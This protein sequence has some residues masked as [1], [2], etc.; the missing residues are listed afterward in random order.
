MGVLSYVFEVF[1]QEIKPSPR[2]PQLAKKK[3][4]L[5]GTSVVSLKKKYLR[6]IGYPK[7]HNHSMNSILSMNEEHELAD[8]ILPY[9]N[10]IFETCEYAQARGHEEAMANKTE[11]HRRAMV[12]KHVISTN[13]LAEQ[14]AVHAMAW[15]GLLQE[16]EE[17]ER[18]VMQL[19]ARLA[20]R[21]KVTP[22][23]EE[24]SDSSDSSYSSDV[25][26]AVGVL[27]VMTDS[28][29]DEVTDSSEDEVSEVGEEREACASRPLRKSA[30][31][32]LKNEVM[33]LRAMAEQ[34]T[35]SSRAQAE[36]LAEHE[37]AM[38]EQVTDEEDEDEEESASA[39][40]F[41]E[42]EEESGSDFSEVEEES[43]SDFSEVVEVRV[44]R[45]RGSTNPYEQG[46]AARGV[47]WTR[48][49]NALL[50]DWV[51]AHGSKRW[52]WKGDI[53]PHRTAPQCATRW[54]NIRK[55][56]GMD[57]AAEIKRKYGEQ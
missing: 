41:S 7:S 31:A 33:E 18:E 36:K 13:A 14:A 53:L 30:T 3:S 26:E 28:S 56:T 45:P 9:V 25:G 42:V 50:I 10:W 22:V 43:G 57:D 17:L 37:R 23:D 29:E 5:E 54:Q 2:R 27:V 38:A 48:E 21:A 4:W 12:K 20:K 19:R 16:K 15:Q 32:A 8:V 6:T 52:A 39:S 1:I 34:M 47:A 44:S 35:A 40:D 49:E 24:E 46:M 55:K 11:L 51:I